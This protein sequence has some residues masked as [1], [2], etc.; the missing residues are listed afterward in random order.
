MWVIYILLWIVAVSI[1]ARLFRTG[2]EQIYREKVGEKAYWEQKLREDKRNMEK[3][4]Y[5]G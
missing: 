1:V 5:G 2:A 3:K 4:L